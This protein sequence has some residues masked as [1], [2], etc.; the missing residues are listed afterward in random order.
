MILRIARK[1]SLEML[2]DGRFRWAVG[3]VFLLLM[4]SLL[5]GWKQYTNV[6]AQRALSQEADRDL[7]VSQGEK[8]QHSAAHFGAY[9]FKPLSPLAAV[10]QGVLPYTGVSVF[11]EAHSVKEAAYRPADDATAAHRLGS[12]TAASTL[13]ILIPLLI[14]MLAFSA[15]AGER[16]QGTLRQLMSLGLRRTDLAL[17]KALGTV[18]PLLVLIVPATILGVVALAL[19]AGPGES[20]WSVARLSMLIG[21][22]LCYL[23]IFMGLALIV[24]ARAASARSALVILLGFWFINSFI[25]PRVA[26]DVAQAIH[27]TPTASAFEAA[28]D[29]D[30]DALPSWT[31]RTRAVQER[32]MAEHGVDTPEAIPAS[33]AGYTLLEA[34]RDETEVYRKHFAALAEVYHTQKQVTQAG[35]V[36]APLV[37]VKLLSMGLAGSDYPHHR[38]FV[39]A[40]EVYRYDLVQTLN[41]DMVDQNASWDARVGAELWESIPPFQYASPG[42]GWAVGQY[43]FSLAVLVVWT[44]ILMALTPVSVAHMKIG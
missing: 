37:S 23:L 29:A 31:D 43:G 42:T 2:R 33:V 18:V 7:W 30:Y 39:E 34:E 11:L 13:Q 36:F 38:H 1:E 19:N 41:Q 3:M 10:D 8:N 40:A 21:I 22:Y 26:T 20:V 24:S 28:L 35:G 4:G 44:L 16:E 17:G 14:I 6:E 25:V 32:L 15:F 12:L 9:A 5:V 27:P